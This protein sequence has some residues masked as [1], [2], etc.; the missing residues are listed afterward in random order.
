MA[1]IDR[2]LA[3]FGAVCLV[4]GC[5]VSFG[6]ASLPSRSTDPFAITRIDFQHFEADGRPSPNEGHRHSVDRT[7]TADGK[8][9]RT[10][11]LSH[12]TIRPD[13]DAWYAVEMIIFEEAA[14]PEFDPGDGWPRGVT[15]PPVD[16]RASTTADLALLKDKGGRFAISYE[17]AL[18]KGKYRIRTNLFK[19]DGPSTTDNQYERVAVYVAKF[20]V[21]PSPK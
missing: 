1:K 12:A 7:V 6:T 16:L 19:G 13:K 15:G 18:P 17:V 9:G 20:E 11:V 14:D 2:I 5:F 10:T 4:A 8:R 21:N 3:L